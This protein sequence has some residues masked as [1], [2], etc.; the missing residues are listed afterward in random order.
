MEKV[1]LNEYII[2]IFKQKKRL[3]A[4]QISYEKYDTYQ[5]HSANSLMCHCTPNSKLVNNWVW[6]SWA[7]LVAPLWTV[8]DPFLQCMV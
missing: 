7:D 4:Y 8:S 6:E 3:K 2:I 1:D 5:P